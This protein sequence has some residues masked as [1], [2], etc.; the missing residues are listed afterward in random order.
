MWEWLRPASSGR[1]TQVW[2]QLGLVVGL[3]VRAYVYVGWWER[4]GDDEHGLFARL[5]GGV[6][7]WTPSWY[8]K[9][10]WTDGGI[11]L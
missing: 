4:S 8:A 7:A 3:W 1:V 2:I 10:E 9:D 5:G 11:D 6:E